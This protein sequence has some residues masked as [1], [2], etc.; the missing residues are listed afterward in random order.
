M[1]LKINML[2]DRRGGVLILVALMFPLLLTITGVTVDLGRQYAVRARAQAA[3]DAGLLGAVTTASTLNVSTETGRL[4]S[5]NY[6]LNY[7]GATVTGPS[8]TGSGDGPY[9]ATVNVTLPWVFMQIFSVATTQMTLTSRVVRSAVGQ[10]LEL[11]LV[12]D[13]SSTVN[14]AQVRNGTRNFITDMFNGAAT[15]PSTYVSVLPFSVMVNVSR[16]P[17][18]RINWAQNPAQFTLLGGAGTNGYFANRNP[19][20]PPDANYA[21]VTDVPPSAILTTRF[22]TPYGTS[23]WTFNN[24]DFVSAN[25]VQMLFAS[26]V[27]AT[28]DARL[29]TMRATGRTRT[30]VGLMWGW[31]SLSPRWTGVWDAGRPG[32][33][34]AASQSATKAI[35]MVVGS[36][37]NVYTGGTQT[38][39]PGVCAVSN[40]NTTTRQLCAAIKGQGIR[41]YTIGYGNAANY[42]AALLQ[43]CSSGEGYYRTA[44]S[45]ATLRTAYRSI[46]DGIKYNAIRLI[47]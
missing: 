8:V 25:L 39:G 14:S 30:N 3:L 12:L 38:C 2:R 42:D 45:Q 19:D 46:I 7:M 21:D 6:P 13:S 32:F 16:T 1:A 5:A 9:T 11:A 17:A 4:F 29:N 31:Y 23:P 18:A 36:R 28:I 26:N 10:Q 34:L 33:P 35:V 47:Q 15:L 20:I 41:I 22:R 43:E 24:G 27:R 44:T 37:N 40:D